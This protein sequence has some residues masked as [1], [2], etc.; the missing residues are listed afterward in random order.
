M[1][2]VQDNSTGITVQG[3]R[4]NNLRFA[5]NIDMIEESLDQLRENVG[6]LGKKGSKAEL[7]INTGKTKNNGI[8]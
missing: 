7:K 4:I 3:E 6:E 2:G 8:W 5:D 1:D